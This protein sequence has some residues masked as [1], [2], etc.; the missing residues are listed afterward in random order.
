MS[1]PRRVE[2]LAERGDVRGL[3]RAL[4]HRDALTRRAA[5]RALGELRDP[6]GVPYLKRALRDGDPYV[7]Q[8]AVEALRD[9]GDGG[10][11]EVLTEAAFSLQAEMAALATQ[12][13]ASLETPQAQAAHRLRDILARNAFDEIEALGETARQP[14]AAVLRSEQFAVWPSAKRRAVLD[15]AVRMGV[16]PP[17]N[18]ATTLAEMGLYVSGL[19]TVGD[20]LRGLHHRSPQ[21]R[22]AAAERLAACGWRWVRWLLRWRF[23]YERSLRGDPRV[24]AALARALEHLGDPHGVLYYKAQ[25]EAAEGHL[26]SQ[27][28]YALAAIGTPRAVETLFAFAA[29][30]DTRSAADVAMN[31]LISIGPSAV[32]ILHPLMA[33]G[34]PHARRLMVD[35]IANSAHP[36]KVDLLTELYRDG[37]SEVQRA[38]LGALAALNSA[39]AAQALDALA[40]DRPHEAVIRAL[41]AI[42]HP[43]G[44]RY[45]QRH[46]PHATIVFGTLQDSD[47][48]PPPRAYV[49]VL[50]EQHSVGDVLARGWQPLGP[51]AETDPEGRFALALLE[52]DNHTRLRLKVTLLPLRSGDPTEI[53][54]ADLPLVIGQTNYVQAQV[55]RLFERLRV[56]VEA[57][58]PAARR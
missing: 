7:R 22:I 52:A 55:D 58:P 15:V 53:F 23:R 12:A 37:I 24:A 17:S 14:L 10:A 8:Q 28:A 44:P 42:T 40:S 41:A 38:A 9:I 18:L 43:A 36:A 21:V 56:K 2:Q 34:S 39:E 19:H 46:V 20:L 30:T 48:R 29:S 57:E 16:M 33:D 49:Q 31:A 13:L 1:S 50:Q 27:A 5:A 54:E 47:R 32:D 11:V 6:K 26:A 45:L 4:R 51:R 25:L 3:C 35:V